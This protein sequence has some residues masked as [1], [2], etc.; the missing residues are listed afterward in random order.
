MPTRGNM[1]SKVKKHKTKQ[2]YGGGTPPERFAHSGKK[3]LYGMM[4]AKG[5]ANSKKKKM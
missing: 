5:K 3:T 2:A 4:K 1:K